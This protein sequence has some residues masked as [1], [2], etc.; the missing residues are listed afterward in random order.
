[1]LATVGPG[2][3]AAEV[4]PAVVACGVLA[5]VES[6]EPQPLTVA[7]ISAAAASPV[8][9]K[10]PQCRLHTRS[11]RTLT[12]G[13]DVA[14]VAEQRFTTKLPLKWLHRTAPP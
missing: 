10:T 6:P 13:F 14:G 7:A 12:G 9:R 8:N 1:M 2:A 4:G 11:H 3:W 5:T